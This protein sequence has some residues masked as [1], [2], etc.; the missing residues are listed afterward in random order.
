MNVESKGHMTSLFQS[1]EQVLHDVANVGEKSIAY[2]DV[3][4]LVPD[5][6]YHIVL[7]AL[8]GLV[9]LGDQELTSHSALLNRTVQHGRA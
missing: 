5:P 3:S 7:I 6:K 9:H 4:P 2:D 8:E 1:L